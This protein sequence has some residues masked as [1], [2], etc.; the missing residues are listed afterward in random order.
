MTTPTGDN[1][2]VYTGIRDVPIYAG[3]TSPGNRLPGGPYRRPELFA[4]AAITIP[5]IW[6]VRGHVDSGCALP[7]LLGGAALAVAVTAALRLALPKRRPALT[8]RAQFLYRTIR[9]PHRAATA[10]GA[11]ADSTK[12]AH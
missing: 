8:T 12:H 4:I 2:K 3:E 5:T 7:V 6:W 11:E 10:H 1:A 9:P